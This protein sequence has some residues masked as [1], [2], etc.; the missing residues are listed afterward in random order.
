MIK[1][2]SFVFSY[3]S[4]DSEERCTDAGFSRSLEEEDDLF[5]D[6]TVIKGGDLRSESVEANKDEKHQI[7][8]SN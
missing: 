4:A 3:V 6:T 8:Q 1:F 7:K 5:N 2:L